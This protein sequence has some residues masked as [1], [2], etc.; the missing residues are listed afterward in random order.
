VHKPFVTGWALAL[1]YVL[2]LKPDNLTA[3]NAALNPGN[4]ILL[5]ADC[6]LQD[7]QLVVQAPMKRFALRLMQGCG[8]F[9]L[10]RSLSAGMARI[11]MYHNFSGPG[12]ADTD[13]VSASAIR[14]QLEHLRRHFQV[15]SLSR[16]VEQL[17]AGNRP[18]KRAV[19]LTIDDGRRN[20]YE[21]LFPILKEFGIPAT[22]FVVSS[23]IRGDD[24]VWTDKILWLS[25]QC[26]RPNE[27]APERIDG[28]FRM[29]N[30]MEPEARNAR[31]EA[32]AT[33]IGVSIP[34]H[35]P[36]KYAP[37]SWSEL[38]EMSE[39]GLVEIGS[40]TVNHPILASLT[41]EESWRELTVSRA[42][43]EEG[44]GL[45][46]N[47]FCFPNGKPDDYRPSQMRQ[48]REAGYT[49]AVVARFGMVGK[50]TDPYELPRIGVSGRSDALAFAKYLDGAEYYQ[51]RLQRSLLLRGASA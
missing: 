10:S 1:R 12:E 16:I 3:L 33:G 5:N 23:F 11:L 13:A 25:E 39:S 22:L 32:M 9:T 40:H 43:I 30:Q 51:A 14:S 42:H 36:P 20:C 18:D 31:I 47:S 21:F 4:D 41:D 29:L 2:R 19:A 27:A 34:N 35:P 38:R 46:V 44:V 24:W 49:S 45:R 26:P 8:M 50:A 15:V 48:V 28:L 7:R 6:N 17:T 37:C